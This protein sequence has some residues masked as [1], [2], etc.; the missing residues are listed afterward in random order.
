VVAIVKIWGKTVGAVMWDP[1]WDIATFEFD[2]AFKRSGLDLSPIYMPNDDPTTIYSFPS[3]AKDYFHGLPGLL[4]QSLPERFGAQVLNQYLLRMGRALDGINPVERLCMLSKRGM[5]ALEFEPHKHHGD[6][7]SAI[8]FIDD[9]LEQGMSLWPERGGAPELVGKDHAEKLTDLLRAGTSA[10]GQRAKAV[11]AINESTGEVRSGQ[12]DAPQGF[13]HWMIKLDGITNRALH[14]PRGYG[15]IEYA[16]YIMAQMAGIEMSESTLLEEK[17]HAHFLT[18][19]FDRT[20]DGR[21]IHVQSLASL[22]HANPYDGE[23]W[24]YEDAFQVV[25]LLKLDYASKQ[26]LFLR[27]VFNVIAAN[28]DDHTENISFLMNEKGQWKL[29]PAYDLTYSHS[30]ELRGAKRH[31][32]SINGKR[33]HI[34]LE[35]L[36][37]V[38]KENGIKKP[39]DLIEQVM[40]AVEQWSDIAKNAGIPNAQANVIK[41]G[42]KLF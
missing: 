14:D 1:N 41:K 34:S 32:L 23:G 5:G 40:A 4:S 36:R 16:Y 20:A 28:Y 12:T 21:K 2:S 29:A 3:L 17:Q 42:L 30:S 25:R 15:R 22:A 31:Q 9:L 11:L 8:V 26:Q 6:N 7:R 13:R 38:A 18:L 19:R 27:M 10:G 33:E 24:S 35:D 37:T 39:Q